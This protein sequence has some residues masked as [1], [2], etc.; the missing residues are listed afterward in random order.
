MIQICLNLRQN[1][2]A[3][4]RLLLHLLVSG[5]RPSIEIIYET[6][7]REHVREDNDDVDD[8]GFIEEDA[9]RFVREYVG[10]VAGSYLMP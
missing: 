5:T 7:K 4:H 6:P 3:G 10:S 9:K 2:D 8:D 1:L